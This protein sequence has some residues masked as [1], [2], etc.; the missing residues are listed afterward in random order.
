M[1]LWQ[2]KAKKSVEARCIYKHLHD[3]A[4]VALQNH[5]KYKQK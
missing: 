2:L 3:F 1:F 5:K 4:K